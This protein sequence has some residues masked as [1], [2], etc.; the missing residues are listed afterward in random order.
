MSF[1]KFLFLKFKI[2]KSHF[3]N[4]A[5]ILQYYTLKNL[6]CLNIISIS[7]Q[8]HNIPSISRNTP[9]QKFKITKYHISLL[10]NLIV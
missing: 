5:N 8:F 3:V 7:L 1:I 9:L 4:I 10:R 2:F 6:R